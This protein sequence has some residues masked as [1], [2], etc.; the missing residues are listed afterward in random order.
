LQLAIRGGQ[1]GS[2]RIR[3]T[4]GTEADFVFG[5]RRRLFSEFGLKAMAK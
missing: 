4:D 3:M 5:T 1:S 2:G